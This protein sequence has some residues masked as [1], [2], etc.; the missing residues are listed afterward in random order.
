MRTWF[1][2]IAA[3]LVLYP[4]HGVAQPILPEFLINETTIGH[5]SGPVVDHDP[6][7]GQF[8][9]G[10]T[11]DGAEGR[12]KYLRLFSGAGTPLSG[13]AATPGAADETVTGIA[14]GPSGTVALAWRRGSMGGLVAEAVVRQFAIDGTPLTAE[15]A[16]S[17]FSSG[18][19][20]HPDVDMN[21]AGAYVVAYPQ[22]VG[23][24]PP[25]YPSD[26]PIS[27][28]FFQR[29][30]FNGALLGM[31]VVVGDARLNEVGVAISV[32]G[33]GAFVVAWVGDDF[34]DLNTGVFVR[35][36]DPAGLPIGPV[37]T[38]AAPAVA[39]RPDVALA[40]D[41]S[42]VV[43]WHQGPANSSNGT[44]MARRYDNTAMPLGP[45][46]RVDDAMQGYYGNPSVCIDHVDVTTVAWTTADLENSFFN[47]NVASRRYGMS[48]L[49]ISGTF[50]VNVQTADV[51]SRSDV[52]G[53]ANGGFVA[54]W[55]S[56]GQDGSGAGI[57]GRL[58]PPEIIA[59]EVEDL[60]ITSTGD[61]VHIAWRLP[62]DA[63]GQLGG[64]RVQRADDV[65]GPWTD[66]TVSPLWPQSMMSFEESAVEPGHRY[67]YRLALAEV[68]GTVTYSRAVAITVGGDADSRVELQVRTPT[69]GDAPVEIRYRIALPSTPVELVVY[70]VRGR[71]VRTIDTGNR[72]PGEYVLF[73]DRCD[74]EGTRVSRGVYFVELGAGSR[75]LTERILLVHD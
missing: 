63:L 15:S 59:V 2:L 57:F 58:F 28:V 45:E 19:E 66:R 7:T 27:D 42:F 46:F 14:L 65:A 9:V 61:R 36:Y 40:N 26:L 23:L 31:P 60:V 55:E 44:I 33:L 1:V 34:G 50:R 51:Q 62:P 24:A 38:V 69:G 74:G 12:V 75:R 48:G 18:V 35:A 56:D 72:D 49:P 25:P 37:E 30:D 43:V 70:D 54:V 11:G 73:W 67:W 29:Y 22:Q 71:A 6:S 47:P 17:M 39:G 13:E 5:Q 53:L 16:L 10:W 32:N 41:G 68:A 8:I 21:G 4:A 20:I 52:A 64:I 3:A